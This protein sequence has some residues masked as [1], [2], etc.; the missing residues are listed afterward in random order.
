MAELQ[1]PLGQVDR[2]ISAW[3]WDDVMGSVNEEPALQPNL[4]PRVSL[5]PREAEKRDPGN[6]VA[7]VPRVLSLPR[8]R[9]RT[10][11]TRLPV[12]WHEG[13]VV[14]YQ[15]VDLMRKRWREGQGGGFGIQA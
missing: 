11:G 8:G 9:E 3:D 2:P 7:L 15:R 6:E 12:L 5:Q 4:V 14:E 1:V 10:L 13:C